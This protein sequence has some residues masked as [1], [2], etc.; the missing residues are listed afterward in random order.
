MGRSDHCADTSLGN[1][2]PVTSPS[3]RHGRGTTCST[4]ILSNGCVARTVS[5]ISNLGIREGFTHLP[6]AEDERARRR[7]HAKDVTDAIAPRLDTSDPTTVT[8]ESTVSRV[9]AVP[10]VSTVPD[11]PDI[12]APPVNTTLASG[13]TDEVEHHSLSSP[14]PVIDV[15]P[16]PTPVV[17]IQPRPTPV[18]DV[19]PQPTTP[20]V[21]PENNDRVSRSPSP[22][23]TPCQSP[24][25]NTLSITPAASTTGDAVTTTGHSEDPTVIPTPSAVFTFNGSS[26]FIT[27]STITYWETIQ[28]GQ[29]WID[30]IRAYLRLEELPAP[31]GVRDL[32]L[33]SS[34]L[35]TDIPTVSSPPPDNVPTGGN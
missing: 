26:N 3:R 14:T 20:A 25:N 32:F 1:R 19:Q 2:G 11:I 21:A 12:A 10:G 35:C 6:P 13:A 30:M 5:D 18:V 31:P 7:G 27:S 24:S 4:I 16:Q 22:L 15:Q 33:F 29:A 9:S 34:Q 8:K 17:D 23:G 28:G